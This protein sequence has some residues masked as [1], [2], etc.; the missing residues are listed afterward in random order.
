MAALAAESSS[1]SR[2]WFVAAG[3][4]WCLVLSQYCVVC[5]EEDTQQMAEALGYGGAP[6]AAEEPA[7]E[8]P[9]SPP[10]EPTRPTGR[11]GLE[12]GRDVSGLELG[13]V[14]RHYQ[15]IDIA[16]GCEQKLRPCPKRV[17]EL[18]GQRVSVYVHLA[19]IGRD[20]A[21]PGGEV[22]LRHENMDYFHVVC[23][24]RGLAGKS[25]GMAIELYAAALELR[26]VLPVSE[27][28]GDVDTSDERAPV[29]RATIPEGALVLDGVPEGMCVVND[30]ATLV[31]IIGPAGGWAERMRDAA[32]D[33]PLGVLRQ[34]LVDRRD[35]G[36]AAWAEIAARADEA[37]TPVPLASAVHPERVMS[38]HGLASAETVR[39]GGG[40][41]PLGPRLE[42]EGER[43]FRRLDEAER[44]QRFVV[45]AAGAEAGGP[46]A[47]A[48][49]RRRTHRQRRWRRGLADGR[50]GRA[51]RC[52][53]SWRTRRSRRPLHLRR[54]SLGAARSR[55]PR[56]RR[57][58][59]R[60]APHRRRRS[61][62]HG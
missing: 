58:S 49:V 34:R 24:V 50:A 29:T 12:P 44:A 21:S 48:S 25:N 14:S 31:G 16:A 35:A 47:P 37:T 60:R 38:G 7:A 57:R 32:P 36:L 1:L 61:R 4:I 52:T 5:R 27:L 30:C 54:E 8:Q 19:G 11:D 13:S 28:D 40:G 9:P 15:F 46:P 41:E 17:R 39:L 22:E 56:R 2:V 42:P 26:L 45:S 55:S 53:T 10:R 62:R 59:R 6:A 33:E 43:F 3:A 51:R 18:H 23:Q 20:Y